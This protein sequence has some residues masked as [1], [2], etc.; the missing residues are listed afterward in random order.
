MQILT[1]LGSIS[2]RFPGPWGS[3]PGW[4]RERAALQPCGQ[5]T[6]RAVGNPLL[7]DAGRDGR[8]CVRTCG[9]LNIFMFVFPEWE[10]ILGYYG[11]SGFI[12]LF[13]SQRSHLTEPEEGTENKDF[14][15]YTSVRHFS[16]SNTSNATTA[17][18]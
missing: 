12:R 16:H 15:Q 9:D 6:V 13:F 2:L 8:C 17:E 11:I 5:G 1:P 7:L 10:S 4:R 3:V 18:E 14:P